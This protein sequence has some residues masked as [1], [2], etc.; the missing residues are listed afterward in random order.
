M[1]RTRGCRFVLVAVSP[2]FVMWFVVIFDF[3]PYRQID[4]S[5]VRVVDA[6]NGSVGLV[7]QNIVNLFLIIL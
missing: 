3:N 1:G 2:G 4:F 6:H 5:Y 7:E